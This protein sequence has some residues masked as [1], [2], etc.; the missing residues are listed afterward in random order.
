M[1]FRDWVAVFVEGFEV[2]DNSVADQFFHFGFCICGGDATGQIRDVGG[3]AV[4]GSFDEDGVFRSDSLHEPYRVSHSW[5]SPSLLRPLLTA[6]LPS[7]SD[8]A[9]LI[10]PTTGLV[11]ATDGVIAQSGDAYPL[12][13]GC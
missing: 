3:V 8:Y 9:P 2:E 1:R 4:A 6:A 11:A 10:R 5:H 7:L 13:C 12:E